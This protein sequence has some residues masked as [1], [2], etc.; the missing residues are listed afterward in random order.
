MS[1][2]A[3]RPR[4]ATE[5]VDA[6]VQLA[7]RHYAPLITLGALVAIPSVLVGVLSQLV[8]RNSSLG[9]MT[10]AL[11][12]VLLPFIFLNGCWTVIGFGAFVK[13]TAAAYLDGR[14]LEPTAALR[15][16]LRHAWQLIAGN[17]L[18]GLIVAALFLLVM[19]VMFIALMAIGGLLAVVGRMPA[20]S[21]AVA[22][23]GMVMSVL[24]M[25]V[26]GIVALL[27][28]SQLINVTAIV[29]L[30]GLGPVNALRRSRDLVRGSARHTAAVLL[31]L[32]VLWV[33]VYGTMIFVAMLALRRFELAS[34]VAGALT[35]LLYP[36][37]GCLLT[38]LY[39]DL[40]IRHE[41]YDRELMARALEQQPAA[42]VP[43]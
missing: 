15:A 23:V 1:L 38:L 25:G 37:F 39:Y 21:A 43:V 9:V 26:G 30:E 42:G 12:L 28:W 19:V 29:V 17:V 2:S 20:G 3:F 10:G 22:A 16:A 14:A 40:R 8:I 11:A 24:V 32:A 27:V 18:A 13:A 4:S 41:G 35:V 7:R 34:T 6:A 31:L 36:F 33:V 5:L